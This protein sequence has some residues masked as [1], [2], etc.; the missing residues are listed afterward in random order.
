M[1]RP[2]WYQGN[3]PWLLVTRGARS[4]SQAILVIIVPLYASAAGYS[5]AQIGLLLT[6]AMAGSVVMTIGVGFLSDFIGRKLLLLAISALATIGAFIFSLTTEF[7]ILSIMA[8]LTSIRGGGAG[9]GG[10]FGPFYPAEQALVAESSSDTN[11]NRVFSILSFV[12]VLT[13]AIGSLLAGLPHLLQN[14]LHFSIISSF[15]PTFWIAA[16][17]SLV[18]LILTLPIQEKHTKSVPGT[19]RPATRS[20]RQLIGRLWLTN[21]IN[22]IVIGVIGPYLTYWFVLRYHANTGEISVLYT[23]ANLLTAVSYLIAPF[24]AHRLGAVRT[25]VSTRATS[26]VLMAVMAISPTFALASMSYIFRILVNSIGLP[27]RQSFVMGVSEE[28]NRSEVA[29]LGTLPAQAT[30][31]AS[32][33]I[34]SYLQMIAET[35]PIWV[36]TAASAINAILWSYF[37]RRIKPPEEQ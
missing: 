36:A 16:L 17:F 27:I 37:F 3:I 14:N 22:G 20:T 26:V 24:V 5:A 29:A 28:E 23:V 1:R 32:P 33:I 9:S 2:E 21:G 10:G 7:W 25:I 31:I 18:T 11:R 34:A 6:I 30:G 35:A 19:A 12:G 13:G 4:L 8:A 15:Q